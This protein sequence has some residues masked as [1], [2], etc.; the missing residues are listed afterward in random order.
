MN[1]NILHPV[2][3]STEL[4]ISSHIY[5]NIDIKNNGVSIIS[6]TNKKGFMEN[7]LNNYN[8]QTHEKK[9]LIIILNN[10]NLKIDLWKKAT[11]KYK[12]I[13]IYQL[14]EKISLGQ[15]LNYGVEKSSYD[16]IAKFD[17]D[18][19]YGPLYTSDSLKAFKFTEADLIGKSTT[20]VFFQ[21]EKILALKNI[22]KDNRYV[23]RVEGA[24][25][26]FKKSLLNTISFRNKNLGEDMYFCKDCINKGFKTYST[27]KFHYLYIRNSNWNHTWSIK[28][29][30]LLRKSKVISRDK[31]FLHILDSF[32]NVTNFK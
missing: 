25:M 5:K 26:F 15:C 22:N 14:D 10:N 8:R 6:C 11:Q 3:K 24:T 28:N 32:I 20:F 2:N 29:K 4:K 13:N 12:N 31:N 27:N 9:E 18:D 19:Y 17:D 23:Y 30:D 21:D 7:I 16:I 1:K